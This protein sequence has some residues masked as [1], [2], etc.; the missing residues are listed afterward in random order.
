MQTHPEGSPCLSDEVPGREGRT[1]PSSL[2]HLRGDEVPWQ[3]TMLG[4]AKPG[5]V[6]CSSRCPGSSSSTTGVSS[7]P[8][9]SLNQ[10]SLKMKESTRAECKWASL[11]A[12]SQKIILGMATRL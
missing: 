10:G 9:S 11:S 6:L 4:S 5:S 7:S 8:V 1:A 12:C 3:S 2:W